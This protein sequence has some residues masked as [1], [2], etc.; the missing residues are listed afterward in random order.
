MEQLLTAAQAA[1]VLQ[2]TPW[3]VTELCRSGEIRASKPGKSWR[4]APVDLQAYLDKHS[5]QQVEGGAA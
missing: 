2:Q 4:I 1:K 5:N 3:T